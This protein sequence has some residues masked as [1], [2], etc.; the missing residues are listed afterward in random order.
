MLTSGVILL[1]QWGL[2]IRLRDCC[3][4]CLQ[5]ALLGTALP[6][7]QQLWG[8]HLSWGCCGRSEGGSEGRAS[9]VQRKRSVGEHKCQ[10]KG[11]PGAVPAHSAAVLLC[12]GPS[13]VRSCAE[14]LQWLCSGGKAELCCTACSGPRPRGCRRTLPSCAGPAHCCALRG[15][16][17]GGLLLCWGSTLC[18]PKHT[19]DHEVALWVLQAQLSSVPLWRGGGR[20]APSLQLSP[21]LPSPVPCLQWEQAPFLQKKVLI[22]GHT[23]S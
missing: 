3:G 13:R 16:H 5:P 23:Q 14:F 8:A 17:G 21:A 6:R 18:H 12:D 22:L 2:Y 10:P 15:L 11:E 4:R 19:H 1:R 20:A 9:S 7:A